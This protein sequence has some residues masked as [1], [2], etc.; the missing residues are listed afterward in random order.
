MDSQ[1]GENKDDGDTVPK[2][3]RDMCLCY[4]NFN[5]NKAVHARF[6]NA[7]YM[8]TNWSKQ[9]F[10]PAAGPQSSSTQYDPVWTYIYIYMHIYIYIYALDAITF[11]SFTIDY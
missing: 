2:K 3:P 5:I 1:N 11:T 7:D 8:W 4:L 6:S 9:S 10:L